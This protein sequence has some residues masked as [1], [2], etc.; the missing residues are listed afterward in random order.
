MPFLVFLPALILVEEL[1][2][3]AVVV[4]AVVVGANVAVDA[5]RATVETIHDLT[6]SSS[7]TTTQC[8]EKKKNYLWLMV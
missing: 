8:F 6:H 4:G 3:A 5:T 2:Q 7:S 1:V